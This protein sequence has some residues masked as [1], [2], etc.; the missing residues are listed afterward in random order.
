MFPTTGCSHLDVSQRPQNLTCFKQ[1]A[2]FF[3][4]F[5]VGGA[6]QHLL[7][8]PRLRPESHFDASL[9]PVCSTQLSLGSVTL[10]PNLLHAL[11]LDISDLHHHSRLQ[12][13]PPASE[14]KSHDRNSSC[15][16]V[17]GKTFIN[18]TPVPALSRELCHL[19]AV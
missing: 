17:T 14:F 5:P 11:A 6:E 10:S 2:F 4:L 1:K 9:W 13:V 7:N 15:M 12:A 8:L 18:G 19:Q 3:F 16:T